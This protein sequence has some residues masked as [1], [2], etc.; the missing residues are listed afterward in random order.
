MAV[1]FVC[2]Q[3]ISQEFKKSRYFVQS[4]GMVAT[5]EK[6]GQRVFN[7]KD[8][9]AQFYNTSYRTTI[10]AQGKVGDIKFYVDYAIRDE[11]FAVYVNDNF[12]EFINTF[13][14]GMVHNK[15]ID[16]YL[17]HLLK[18]AEEAYEE[19]VKNDELKK[20]EDKQPGNPD[21][22]FQNPGNVTYEDLKAYLEQQRQNRYK[23]NNTI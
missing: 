4:L 13:D 6:N 11:N 14:R 20:V 16:F 17:G 22:I 2:G 19:K 18:M 5:V 3:V 12:E 9:F 1:Y 21:K 8:R 10:Y 23:N 7:E 15:G